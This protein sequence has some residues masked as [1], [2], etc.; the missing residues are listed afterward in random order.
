MSRAWVGIVVV[1]GLVALAI[2]ASERPDWFPANLD[3]ARLVYLLMALLLVSGAG[4]GFYRVRNDGARAIV[5]LA[6]WAFIIVAIVVA[7]TLLN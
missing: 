2:V 1:L 5:G 4:Y 6:I 3:V 7:Y